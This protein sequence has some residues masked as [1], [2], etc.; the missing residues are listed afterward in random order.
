MQ[1]NI[2]HAKSH[3]VMQHIILSSCETSLIS[4]G[5][6]AALDVCSSPHVNGRGGTH[7]NNFGP[8]ENLYL[9]VRA[10]GMH[11]A[12]HGRTN[13]SKE[14]MSQKQISEDAERFGLTKYFFSL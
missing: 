7:E 13:E 9:S 4:A 14:K 5:K 12:L 2:C 11:E 3:F 6:V 8:P 1:D 10:S